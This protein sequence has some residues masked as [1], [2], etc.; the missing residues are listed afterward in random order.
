MRAN[1]RSQM[2]GSGTDAVLTRVG[3]MMVAFGTGRNVTKADENNR[4][5]QTLYS[6]LDNTR[7]RLNSDKRLEIHPGTGTCTTPPQA[8]C[9]PAPKA[10]GSGAASAGLEQRTIEDAG[11]TGQ[12]RIVAANDIDWTTQNGF[13]LDYPAT[14]ERQLK[15]INF[16]DS[17][18]SLNVFS[19]VP[20]KGSDAQEDV[21]S[22]ESGSVDEERQ[23]Q[24]LVNIMDG[25]RPTVQ[26]IDAN[27][28]GLYTSADSGISRTP[29]TKGPHTS[30]IIPPP[31]GGPSTITDIDV[32]NNKRALARMPEQ[33]LRPSWR[34]LK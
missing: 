20:A 6:V 15:S 16:Y 30:V 24:T 9:V 32:N 8:D 13:Y 28:D 7:Y 29:V 34:Q 23:Y 33:S 4:N 14:G 11:K 3:G 21:E 17:S 25:K 19:Q 22:C 26:I 1:D 2:V 12:G 31:P 5:M 27:G 18:N 10:L